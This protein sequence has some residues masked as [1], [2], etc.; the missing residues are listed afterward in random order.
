[1]PDYYVGI[2]VLATFVLTLL[3]FLHEYNIVK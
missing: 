1:M 3:V 2:L